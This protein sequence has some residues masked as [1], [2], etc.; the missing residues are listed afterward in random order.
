MAFVFVPSSPIA[1]GRSRA[2]STS[3]LP[4]LALG[5][6]GE[7]IPTVPTVSSAPFRSSRCGRWGAPRPA[8]RLVEEALQLHALDREGAGRHD[9]H[10]Y[11]DR[12]IDF[13]VTTWATATQASGSHS[14]HPQ[15]SPMSR[16]INGYRCPDAGLSPIS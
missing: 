14:K 7:D 11:L 15:L 9:I 4:I 2:Q 10:A 6:P 13:F 12:P 16:C 8:E 1:P 5:P 3:S